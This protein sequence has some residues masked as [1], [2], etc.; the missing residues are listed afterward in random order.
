MDN[1]A[2]TSL[3]VYRDLRIIVQV[4]SG[5]LRID[6]LQPEDI[7]PLGN[8]ISTFLQLCSSPESEISEHER[9][10][11]ANLIIAICN[12]DTGLEDRSKE[13]ADAHGALFRLFRKTI[14]TR[15]NLEALLRMYD[16]DFRT[17]AVRCRAPYLL[18]R[19]LHQH[20][21]IWKFRLKDGSSFSS[22]LI[23]ALSKGLHDDAKKKTQTS[24][25]F[26]SMCCC[27]QVW[28]ALTV[29]LSVSKDYPCDIVH[30]VVSFDWPKIMMS[31]DAQMPLYRGWTCYLDMEV[32]LSL[33]EL[34]QRVLR[35]DPSS[36]DARLLLRK[37]VACRELLHRVL[38]R[39]LAGY[40]LSSQDTHKL[41]IKSTMWFLVHYTNC[42][43]SIVCDQRTDALRRRAHA[44]LVETPEVS[45]LTHI[46]DL[47]MRSDA[48][49]NVQDAV[50]YL[51]DTMWLIRMPSETDDDR[52]ERFQT[53]YSLDD[54]DAQRQ[55]RRFNR[56]NTNA[57]L[58]A[59][60]GTNEMCANCFVLEHALEKNGEKLFL[61]SQCRQIKYCSRKCQREHWKKAHKY[62]CEAHEKAAK[63]KK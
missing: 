7:D 38:N 12:I 6:R 36:I 41:A 43:T 22:N 21:S 11:N 18:F 27:V 19:I 16:A 50:E 30:H 3:D 24:L 10:L 32:F 35:E 45:T 58:E 17:G 62:K 37:L 14:L 28:Q 31:P 53:T 33:H 34:A 26:S 54:A 13:D 61:C 40:L 20:N 63:T 46:V 56:Q 48:L 23:R 8:E 44:Y 47:E 49:D 5:A 25:H 51:S 39:I 57:K 15:D 42:L 9:M 4:A 55:F 52:W 29:A 60:V 59:S 2:S 1:T